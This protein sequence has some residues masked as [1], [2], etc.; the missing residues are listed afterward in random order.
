MVPLLTHQHFS[1]LRRSKLRRLTQT[2]SGGVIPFFD[3][4]LYHYV[5]S[6]I[7][8][9]LSNKKQKHKKLQIPL[10]NP[11]TKVRTLLTSNI[12]PLFMSYLSVMTLGSLFIDLASDIRV[13]SA[14]TPLAHS[15]SSSLFYS[16]TGS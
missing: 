13:S 8:R 7:L 1:A 5:F 6:N 4:Q 16:P 15:H 10:Q 3:I 14:L 9:F 11:N 12:R 2:L